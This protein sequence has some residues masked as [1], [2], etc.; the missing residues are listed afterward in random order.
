M[1]TVH[2][3]MQSKLLERWLGSSVVSIV[4]VVL[5]T[6]PAWQRSCLSCLAVSRPLPA[7]QLSCLIVSVVSLSPAPCRLGSSVLSCLDVSRPLPAWW[8]SCLS[9]LACLPAPAG[10]TAQLSPGP[11][12]GLASRT[13]TEIQLLGA[14]QSNER[15]LAEHKLQ[16]PT[17][18]PGA[19]PPCDSGEH[20]S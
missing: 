4:S 12:L 20:R 2:S 9:C 8:L 7:R 18:C 10:S 6:L 1:D 11:P 17:C 5:R 3:L 15:R 19:A 16:A 13:A 14:A